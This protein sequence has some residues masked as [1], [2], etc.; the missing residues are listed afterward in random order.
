[1]KKLD[2]AL[3][4]KDCEI[5]PIANLCASSKIFEKLILKRILEIQDEARID[6][7]G[8]KQHGFKR[9]RSTSTLSVELL[10]QIARAV[11]DENFVI[12]ASIDL[13][14]AFDLVDINLLLKRLKIIGITDDVVELISA[15][16]RN[17][18]FYVSI[19]GSNSIKFDL[20][21]GT[22]KGSILGP[23]LYV[24][25]VAPLFD[26][27]DLS[28]FAD[29]TYIPRWN[30]SLESLIRNMEKGIEAITKWMKDSS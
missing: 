18:L 20:L 7:T 30:S 1:M 13:S 4:L 2:I 24:I 26:I 19:H 15:L 23:V 22:V 3:N 28:S 5:Q 27:A 6:L 21:L 10:S 9:N 29:D 12:V 14:V 17:R 11:D 25:F 8:S 16:L